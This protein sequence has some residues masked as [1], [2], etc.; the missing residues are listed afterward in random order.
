MRTTTLS[1]FLDQLHTDDGSDRDL[2]A[3]F[4]DG[5]EAA[6]AA[7]VRRHGPM[8]LG[9]CERVLGNR[10]DAEDAYQSTFLA[11]SRQASAGGWRESVAGWLHEVAWRHATKLR[12]RDA[13]RRAR[14]QQARPAAERRAAVTETLDEE[15]T[16]LPA[17][18]RDAVLCCYFEG[19][20]RQQAAQRLG[21][22]LRTLER[23]LEQGRQRL[24]RR[25]EQR[26]EALPALLAGPTV[27]ALGWLGRARLVLGLMLLAGSVVGVG[28]AAW[29]RPAEQDAPPAARPA[30]VNDPLPAGALARLGQTRWRHGFLVNHVTVS[31]DGK[32]VSSTGGGRGVCLWDAATGKL[33]HH[34]NNRR[35]PTAYTSAFSPDGKRVVAAESPFV[36]VYDTA[37]GKLIHELKGHTN[38]VLGVAW[39]DNGK[40]LASGSHDLTVRLWDADSSKEL[41]VLTGHTA[42]PRQVAF[43]RGSKLLASAG[44][45]GTVRV[46]DPLTGRELH[47]FASG[48]NV[49][50]ALA[51]SPDG[52]LLAWGGNDGAVKVWATDDTAGVRVLARDKSAPRALAFT[53]DGKT[54]AVG[55]QDGA[56]RLHDVETGKESRRWPA[57]AFTVQGLCYSPDGKALY[58]G[59]AWDSTVR[60]WA[61]ATGLEIDPGEG[62]VG[63]VDRLTFTPDGRSLL[64]YSR[65][66]RVIRWDLAT[67]AARPVAISR[68]ARMGISAFTADGKLLALGRRGLKDPGLML[69]DVESGKLLRT[70][71]GHPGMTVGLGFS[72]D[73][74]RLVAASGDGEVKVWGVADGKHLLSLDRQPPNKGG[75]FF[76]PAQFS[77]DDR[78][79]LVGEFDN[80]IHLHDAA[81]GKLLRKRPTG[82]EV[83]A[84][85]FSPD[86][87][88]VAVGGGGYREPTVLFWNT[89]TGDVDRSWRTSHSGIISGLAFSLDGRL[90]ATAGDE[91]DST[92]R[93]W[94][95]ATAQELGVFKGHHSSPWAVG[96]SPDGRTLATGGGDSSVLLWDVTGRR[97]KSGKALSVDQRSRLWEQLG[98][99]DA[100]KAQA[101]VWELALSPDAA[102]TVRER[103]KPAKAA[104]VVALVKQ[105]GADDFATRTDATQHLEALAGSAIPGLRAALEAKPE[106][107]VRRRVDGLISRYLRTEEWRR[108][109]RALAALEYAGT[110][111]ARA[112]VEQL[113]GGARRAPLT[114]EARRVLGRMKK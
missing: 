87:E 68:P 47:C 40:W 64:T 89:K 73:G 54:L 110:P 76:L 108:E 25:L 102:A 42:L 20:T 29:P 92:V 59:A 30:V 8:V 84:A 31:A 37:T 5:D 75:R 60:R 11:L 82:D 52:S 96:F 18:L 85:T 44:I 112:L 88:F 62:H 51:F 6:F 90:V 58:S 26:G 100:K 1:S 80:A 104:D 63:P 99:D 81:T 49:H 15:L 111:A 17:K 23:R 16:Q 39:S 22:S 50:E 78:M 27:T 19:L 7:L 38:G 34:C 106:L 24:R 28:V 65:D 4:A 69:F 46:W 55:R 71:I 70:I 10:D 57:H 74:Q 101:A 77:R 32:T 36:C 53:P 2:L 94:D 83:H 113:T 107:E 45:D 13:Q 114:E 66:H 41:F 56:I 97:G 33:L 9:V 43:S 14:E 98:D 93:L 95:V 21:W 67:R 91:V 103:L 79:I 12:V 86:G 35:F 48:D 109:S 3:R 72:H 105:L 61:P